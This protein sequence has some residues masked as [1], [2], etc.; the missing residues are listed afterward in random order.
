MKDYFAKD[1]PGYGPDVPDWYDPE[2]EGSD[3]AAGFVSIKSAIDKS[4]ENSDPESIIKVTERYS[5]GVIK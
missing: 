5:F 1:I 4:L 3:I 2:N